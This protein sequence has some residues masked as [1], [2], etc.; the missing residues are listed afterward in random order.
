M[1]G[2][3]L[4]TFW[5]ESQPNGTKNIS[6]PDTA[7]RSSKKEATNFDKEYFKPEEK[8]KEPEDV[9]VEDWDSAAPATGGND[10]W[11]NSN[12]NHNQNQRNQGAAG[13]ARTGPE[14][15][16]VPT[17][18]S[19]EK[20]VDETVMVFYADNKAGR[21]M[22]VWMKVN[23]PP[24]SN[25]QAPINRFFN[26]LKRGKNE[27]W[28]VCHKEDPTLDWGDFDFEW[29]VEGGKSSTGQG[30]H[31]GGHQGGADEEPAEG[32]IIPLGEDA[33]GFM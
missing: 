4:K 33:I 25:L 6:L 17:E 7:L 32:I 16:E 9:K 2:I 29:E 3:K 13:G 1:T 19:I 24:G 14:I 26:V 28:L 30:V 21:D 31:Y 11:D 20:K 12:W 10:N 22:N 23:K 27:V 18:W 8:E 15:S 5:G